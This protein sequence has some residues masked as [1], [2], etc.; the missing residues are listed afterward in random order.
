MAANGLDRTSFVHEGVTHTPS[1]KYQVNDYFGILAPSIKSIRIDESWTP[2]VPDL[3]SISGVFGPYNNV[4][5]VREVIVNGQQLKILSGS[6]RAILCEIPTDGLGSEGPCIVRVNGIESNMVPI[7]TWKL[8]LNY[9]VQNPSSSAYINVDLDLW[10]RADVHQW[11]NL[12]GEDTVGKKF[13]FKIRGDSKARWAAAGTAVAD[14]TTHTFSGSGSITPRSGGLNHNLQGTGVID[15]KAMTIQL[16]YLYMWD[17]VANDH[18]STPDGNGGYIIKDYA[19]PVLL[20]LKDAYVKL[21]FEPT[22]TPGSLGTGA[23]QI[24]PGEQIGFKGTINGGLNMAATMK[25]DRI[26]PNF[27]PTN[28]TKSSWDGGNR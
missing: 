10:L 26:L 20:T 19:I 24:L 15:T 28:D 13:Y 27:P 16:F 1:V 17:Q 18:T 3:M 22:G 7:T 4:N 21:K 6:E 23:Y 25:W 5:Y 2:G 9:H 11:R 14:S 12:P 8:R